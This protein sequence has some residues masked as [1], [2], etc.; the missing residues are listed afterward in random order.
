MLSPL[1][2]CGLTTEEIRKRSRKAGLFTWDKPAY[3]CL[4][5]RFP[6]GMEITKELLARVEA[7]EKAMMDLGF[8]DLRVRVFHDAARVQV[9]ERDMER[10]LAQRKDVLGALKPYFNVVM[11]DLE[12]RP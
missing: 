8:S 4:A 6:A 7:A 10:L 5:T 1:R 2:V 3:A 12:G 11:L 9:R